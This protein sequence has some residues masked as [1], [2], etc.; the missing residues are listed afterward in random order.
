[1]PA[2][3]WRCCS[4]GLSCTVLSPGPA[5]LRALRPTWQS[6]VH[7]AHLDP[8]ALLPEEELPPP[9]RLERMGAPDLEA[10]AAQKTPVDSTEVNGSSIALL[11]SW[12]G[13]TAL[14]GGDA[15]PDVLLAA[16]DGWLGKDASLDVDLFKLPHHG[17]KANVTNALMKRVRARCYVFS[18]SGEG[19]SQHP[20]DQAVA[21]VIVNSTGAR[22]LAFNYRNA[23][24]EVWD[25]P[26]LKDERGYST[27]YPNAGH[28]GLTIDLL[29]EEAH[30]P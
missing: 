30:R 27:C 28:G 15:H 29:A 8:A 14:L 10:L 23:R 7:E 11:A 24:T 13:R 3:R 21:R 6:A 18:S 9:G 20:N 16:L 5:Q 17:S 4:G 2:R 22:T 1:M 26:T 12:A 25:D 19:R